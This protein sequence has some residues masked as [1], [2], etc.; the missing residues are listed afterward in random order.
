MNKEAISAFIMSI[1]FLLLPD[2]GLSKPQSI[3][4]MIFLFGTAWAC[5]T[6]VECRIEE[7][8]GRQNGRKNNRA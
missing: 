3:C 5:I 1:L 6:W 4:M 2:V 8:G 7:R